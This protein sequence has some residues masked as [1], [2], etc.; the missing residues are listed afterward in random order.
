N[1]LRRF[2]VAPITP[3]PILTAS[4]VT[5][6]IAYLPSV[7]LILGISTLFYGMAWPD[8]WI[9]LLLLLSLGLVAFRSIGLIIASVVNSMQESQII[10]QLLYLPMLFLSGATFP[11]SIM[12]S[13]LQVVAQFIP[14][15]YL[16]TG[17]QGILVQ[18]DSLLVNA[19]PGAAMVV[20]LAVST[21]LSVKLFRWEKDEKMANSAKLWLLAVM[22]PFLLLGTYQAYSRENVAKAKILYREMRRNRALL[23]RGSRILVGDGKVI[24]NGGVL[25]RDGRIQQVFDTPPPEKQVPAEVIEAAGKTLMPGLMDAHTHLTLGSPGELFLEGEYL[26]ASSALRALNG[27]RNAQDALQ[28]GFTGVRDVG[29]DANFVSVDIRRAIERGWFIGPTML[30]T[31]KIIAPFGG[32]SHNI[33]PEMG[34]FWHFE[35]QDADTPDEVR[36]AVRQNIYY[37]ANAIKLVADNSPFYYSEE[38]IRAAVTEAHKAG[39]TVGVHV[40]GGQA[41]RNVIMGGADSVEHGFD[42]SDELLRLMKEKGTVLVGTDFPYEHL[43]AMGTAGGILPPAEV[44]SKNIIDRLRRAHKMGVKLAF[45]TDVVM[46]MPDKSRS[47]MMLDYLAVWTEAG[48][49]PAEIL[50]AMTTNVAELFGWKGQRGAIATGQAADIIATPTSPLENIQALRK[51]QFVMKDGKVVKKQ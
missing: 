36:K 51:V 1:I 17:L 20:T 50:K 13:W 21:L 26:K 45:G 27:L 44:T 10:I 8:R 49:P 12:P 31:G 18:K 14:A 22:L 16:Y 35:Y 28:A 48:V 29:N 6:L 42:L 9:S 3:L 15:S 43:K 34:P 40:M 4:L 7:F 24:Q 2:K 23:I 5:G 38:E 32:Q 47:D 37:G 41:A 19:G 25:I 33:P 30:T 39:L 46:E 11:I